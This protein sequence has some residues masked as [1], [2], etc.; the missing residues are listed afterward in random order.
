MVPRLT[1][2]TV[3]T[4]NDGGVFCGVIC[5]VAQCRMQSVLLLL[6]R[7]QDPKR[8]ACSCEHSIEMGAPS[9]YDR[10]FGNLRH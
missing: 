3:E 10:G 4:A 1:G 7:Y 2:F 8:G 6:R 5:N 9:Q